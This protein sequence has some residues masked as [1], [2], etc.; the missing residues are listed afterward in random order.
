MARGLLEI[1]RSVGAWQRQSR[2]SK[3]IVLSVFAAIVGIETVILI[4]SVYRREQ[5]LLAHLQE[6]S[7]ATLQGILSEAAP[8]LDQLSPATVLDWVRRAQ[9][10][11]QVRGGTLYT[12][13]GQRV[14]SFGEA[15][16]L[17]FDQ[18]QSQTHRTWLD[19]RQRRYDALW[20]MSPLE[21][22][23]LLIVR[24]DTTGI[25]AKV[26][27]FIGRIAGLVVLIS[28]VV[29]WA[30]LVVLQSILIAPILALRDD[31]LRAAPAALQESSL[32]PPEF[33]S[34][35]IAHQDDELGEVVMAFQEMFA[36]I[37]QAIAE[38]R[39][40][41]QS[42][43]ESETRFRT[44]VEQAAEGIFVLDRQGNIID[45]NQFA[46]QTLGYGRDEL[47]QLS[48]ADIHPHFDPQQ[49]EQLWQQLS[50]GKT[51]TFET[52]H[53]RQNGT[54]FPVEIRAG[55]IMTG[56]QQFALGLVRDISE[57][58]QAEKVRTRLAEIGELAAMIV[59]EV[60]NPLATV[61]MALTGFKRFDLPRAGQLRLELAL[62]EAERLQRLL[63][64]ILAYA[65]EQRLADEA[66]ALNDLVAGL[67][68]RLQGLPVAQKRGIQVSMPETRIWVRGDRDKLKQ[69]FINLITNAC[70]AIPEGETVHWWI[71]TEAQQVKICVRNGGE[72]IPPEILPKLTQPFVSTKASGNGLGLAITKRI[73]EAH[74]GRLAIASDGETGTTITVVLPSA[75]DLSNQEETL[76]N[77]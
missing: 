28:G 8:N 13:Q 10:L 56:G 23:Y 40:A 38:R 3:R 52:E 64:E 63:N 59:H 32:A 41:E 71:E 30:T 9:P 66:I 26:V 4:P 22:R 1:G 45:V 34:S 35:A 54:I 25:Q 50:Q 60:R 44:L 42:L 73:V 5:E 39:Q 14:G 37:Y 2:L 11:P 6:L 61:F 55:I 75:P 29:T 33:A 51:K 49:F 46:A 69:V 62:D 76:Q 72:P 24:H 47:L 31:L 7:A 65:K 36:Q 74:G 70:E 58:R 20:Q 21:G 68:E 15:P 17:T 18:V 16:V 27:A 43:R 53:Q 67:V 48:V 57:R 12:A 77:P 19:R